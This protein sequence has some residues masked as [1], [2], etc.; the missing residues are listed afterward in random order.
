LKLRLVFLSTIASLLSLDAGQ[1]VRA[2]KS[3]RDALVEPGINIAIPSIMAGGE[4]RTSITL[5]NLSPFKASVMILFA[6]AKGEDLLLPITGLGMASSMQ[7]SIPARGSYTLETEYRPDL[8]VIEGWG[9]VLN[10]GLGDT[11]GKVG[12]H[13]IVSVGG[14]ETVTPLAQVI[15]KKTLMPFDNRNSVETQVAVIN[16]ETRQSSISFTAYDEEGNVLIERGAMDV[17]EFGRIFVNFGSLDL[18]KGKRG[19]VE[20][21]TSNSFMATYGY[22]LNRDARQWSS[23]PSISLIEWVAQ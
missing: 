16:F 18:L 1:P 14:V 23:V 13:S 5:L 10:D 3:L 11:T 22:R 4:F 12:G 7:F 15:E 6:G 20:I 19:I 8:A 9:I 17:P 21:E 2:G